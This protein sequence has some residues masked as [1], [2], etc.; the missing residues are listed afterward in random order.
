MTF[1]DD[2][3]R[4]QHDDVLDDYVSMTSDCSDDGDDGN[5]VVQHVEAEAVIVVV[6]ALLGFAAVDEPVVAA[7]GFVNVVAFERI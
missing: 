7:L 3:A 1:D 2:D 5:A 4:K 6:V